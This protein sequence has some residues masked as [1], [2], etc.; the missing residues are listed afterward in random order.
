MKNRIKKLRG[1]KRF[2]KKLDLKARNL[3]LTL[4]EDDWYDYW[5]T[6]FDWEGQGNI[7][8]KHRKEFLKAYLVAL[9]CLSKQI[10]QTN[11]K[12]Q[13]GLWIFP[14]DSYSDAIFLHSKKP[15]EDN[16][17]INMDEFV[18]T[19]DIPPVF[20]GLVEKDKFMYG[21]HPNKNDC[22]WVIEHKV[23]NK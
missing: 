11:F 21:K 17:P 2:F 5:H 4:D 15:K 7:K 1:A 22:I 8:R 6:H 16:F 23:Y 3:G 9:E 19:T 20:R 18:W 10:K 14:A 13:C 12:C